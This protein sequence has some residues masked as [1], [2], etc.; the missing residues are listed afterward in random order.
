M[1]LDLESKN[2]DHQTHNL[3]HEHLNLAL[4]WLLILEDMEPGQLGQMLMS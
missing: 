4:R 2:I 3:Y 1:A